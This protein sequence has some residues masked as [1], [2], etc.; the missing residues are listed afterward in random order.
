MCT[1]PAG[2]LA[3][4]RLS[5]AAAKAAGGTGCGCKVVGPLAVSQPEK[6]GV[7]GKATSKRS[8]LSVEMP[9][10]AAAL[11][12]PADGGTGVKAMPSAA[13][14]EAA[15]D[16]ED[17]G[18]ANGFWRR[19]LWE[20]DSH[21]H[22][23]LVGTCLSLR[24]LRRIAA[25]VNLRLGDD[26]PEYRIH[27]MFV[28]AAGGV[29]S[30]SRAMARLMDKLLEKRYA[31][32]L[33]TF[34]EAKDNGALARLWADAVAAGDIP[35]PYWALMVH[36]KAS[37]ALVE[38]A[39]GEVHMLSHLVGAVNRAD[40][41]RLTDLERERAGLEDALAEAKQETLRETSARQSELVHLRGVLEGQRAELSS[42]KRRLV[43]AEAD[44][45]PDGRVSN[46]TA[47]LEGLREQVS[48]EAW[49]ADRAEARA[50]ELRRQVEDLRQDRER[51]RVLLETRNAELAA[52]EA[53]VTSN[54]EPNALDRAGGGA[55]DTI[56]LGRVRIACVGGRARLIPHIRGL[57]ERH[58]GTFLFH[59]GGLEDG[60][61]HLEEVVVK[62]DVVVCPVDCVSHDACLRAKRLCRQSGKRFVPLSSSS[63]SG[64]ARCLHSLVREP[65]VPLVEAAE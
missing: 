63:V 64:F 51:L 10:V 18:L 47:A 44:A 2:P 32:T 48:K 62:A 58:N 38:H 19:R 8:L 55:V 52:L 27:G 53:F 33:A 25:K 21:F 54:D 14:T 56:D 13:T 36:P 3:D 1:L 30:Q 28:G 34:R 26:A 23:S 16:S 22:C 49:R 41:R 4:S 45:D 57:V 6:G 35:G 29:S 39:F 60:R 37:R 46:L 31:R 42:L 15:G 50:A 65:A 24:D 7:N 20:V 12:A 40:V 61:S 9:D 17:K 5:P 11:A 43:V 59:D